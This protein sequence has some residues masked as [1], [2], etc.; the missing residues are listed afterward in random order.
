MGRVV[1]WY[2]YLPTLKAIEIND[3]NGGTYTISTWIRWEIIF[4]KQTNWNGLFLHTHMAGNEP[5]FFQ[6]GLIL[7]GFPF[8]FFSPRKKQHR[9]RSRQKK[10]PPFFSCK[11][12]GFLL[13]NHWINVGKRYLA[14]RHKGTKLS[15]VFGPCPGFFWKC[16]RVG[17]DPK[18]F[19]TKSKHQHG[20]FCIFLNLP[21]VCGD[22]NL[23]IFSPGVVILFLQSCK[24]PVFSAVGRSWKASL[25]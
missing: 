2:I 4:W 8:V 1:G 20:F 19:R 18:N 13:R 16:L 23:T 17:T 14:Q 12:L 22:G 11:K 5:F 6:N 15:D 9:K 25:F 7:V 24:L 3:I 10:Q 21:G